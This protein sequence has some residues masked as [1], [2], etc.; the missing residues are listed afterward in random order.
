M[1]EATSEV[2]VSVEYTREESPRETL[3]LDTQ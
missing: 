3:D 2:E 1:T